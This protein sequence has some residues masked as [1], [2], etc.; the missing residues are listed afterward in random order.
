METSRQAAFGIAA[1]AGLLATACSLDPA[2]SPR[3]LRAGIDGA[4]PASATD[5][6]TEAEILDQPQE[7][8][9]IE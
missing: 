8:G 7:L 1:C 4:T 3:V 6:E 5:P 2:P 9:Y